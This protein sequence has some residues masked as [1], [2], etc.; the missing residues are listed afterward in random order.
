MEARR[1]AAGRRSP[2]RWRKLNVAGV[3]VVGVAIAALVV[4]ARGASCSLEGALAA[5]AEVGAVD[6]G[7]VRVGG[8][9]TSVDSC[10]IANLRALRPFYAVYQR[11]GL[12]SDLAQG[13]A[14]SRSGVVNLYF[15]DGD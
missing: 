2:M 9:R 10:V 8:S 12:D 15:Y 14:R 11:P 1:S 5:H 7:R 6:C 3:I 4:R 13:V